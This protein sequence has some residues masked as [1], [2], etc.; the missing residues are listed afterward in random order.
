[1]YEDNDIQMKETSDLVDIVS[2][3]LND[4]MQDHQNPFGYVQDTHDAFEESLGHLCPH[5]LC[6]VSTKAS[7]EIQGPPMRN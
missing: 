2:Y 4:S 7:W 1:M 3:T 6:N 5:S